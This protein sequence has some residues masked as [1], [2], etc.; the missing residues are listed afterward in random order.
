MAKLELIIPYGDFPN[1]LKYTNDLGTAT[2]QS[3]GTATNPG[4]NASTNALSPKI[5][6]ISVLKVS[7]I[8]FLINTTTLVDDLEDTAIGNIE[9][10]LG[11]R[12][13]D[14]FL[15]DQTFATFK[16]IKN[17]ILGGDNNKPIATI[18]LA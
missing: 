16:I 11:D 7:N 9:I 5:R 17:F 3:P 2:T 14:L 15:T 13:T 12:Y 18:D 1:Q 6:Y 10:Q 4:N 8:D